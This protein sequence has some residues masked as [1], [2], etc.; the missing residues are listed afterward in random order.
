[1]N[2]DL[3]VGVMS[4]AG[5]KITFKFLCK[6]LSMAV[7][8]NH[9]P[10][11]PRSFMFHLFPC[12]SLTGVGVAEWQA[13]LCSLTPIYTTC[14]S[15]AEFAAARLHPN[16]YSVRSVPV[17]S[18]EV[19]EACL[20]NARSRNIYRDKCGSQGKIIHSVLDGLQTQLKLDQCRLLET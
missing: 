16:S 1:M 15:A 20:G 8:P 3:S 10:Q 6:H 2:S 19:R 9:G 18:T 13:S 5:G 12:S 17:Q 14:G 7:V 4:T 11:E